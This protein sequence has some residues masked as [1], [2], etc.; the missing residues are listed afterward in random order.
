MAASKDLKREANERLA[1]CRE[2]KATISGQIEEAYY[3]TAPRRV[4][5]S[6]SRSQNRSK[7]VDDAELMTS[8]GAEV[9]DDFAEMLISSFTPVEAD[10]AERKITGVP[11]AEAE[12]FNR[13][14]KEQDKKIFAAIRASNYYAEKGKAAVP[15]AAIGVVALMIESLGN[16]R[17][18]V[19]RG[20]PVRE[21]E[22]NMGPDGRPDDRWECRNTRY[23]FLPAL[24]PDVN[25]AN[26]PKIAKCIK[27]DGKKPVLVQ[28]GFWRKWDR[29]DDEVW[30]HVVLVGDELVFDAVLVGQGSCPMVIGRF[31]ATPDFAW[32][33]GPTLKCLPELRQLD[34]AREAIV[35]SI[36]FTLRPPRAYEDDGVINLEGGVEPGMFYPKRQAQG[37]TIFEN[38]FDPQPIE[39]AVMDE[40]QLRDRIRR[41]HYVDFPEQK[42]KTPPSASQWLDE[43]VLKQ[44]RIG[45]P[46]HNFWREEPYE[47]F[48]RFRFLCEQRGIVEKIKVPGGASLTP[49]NPAQRAFEN[50]EVLTATRFGQIGASLFPQTW[51]IAVDELATLAKLKEK[52]G[53]EIVQLRSEADIA[54]KT[55][56][57]ASLAGVFG[58]RLPGGAQ[59]QGGAG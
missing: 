41:M 59:G 18:I 49:Y 2:E 40:A 30:Q 44:R 8:F 31:G 20:I 34:Y 1:E 3:F 11:D 22:F 45:T 51:Q 16:D 10:W 56:Q 5:S 13:Q 58:P 53:D 28:W 48:Q 25:F 42:G 17:P 29:R 47:T 55:E 23:R 43:M 24:L 4:R 33:D 14:A 12:A 54:Q 38:I 32:P 26:F 39:P 21:L 57:L 27:E 9:A 37:R 6:T 46:G 19:C 7:P 15:D 50:Q 52:L 35:E 36:D